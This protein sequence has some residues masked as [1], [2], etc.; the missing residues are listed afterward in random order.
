MDFEKAFDIGTI[1]LEPRLQEYMRRKNF[2]EENDIDPQISEEQEFS[3]TPYDLK[4]IKRFKQGKKKLYSSR[5]L[6][7]DPHF[8]KTSA[9]DFEKT[10]DFKLDPRYQRLQKKMQS[11]RDA[12]AQIKNLDN[13][14]E[15]YTIFHQSN[16]YDLKSNIKSKKMAKPYDDPGNDNMD[17]D[18]EN[19]EFMMDSR[20]LML[21]TSRP[22]KSKNNTRGEY[23]YNPNRKSNNPNN[24]H[25]TPKITY[26]QRLAPTK[27]SLSFQD[28]SPTLPNGGLTHS[29]SVDDVIGN[30]DSYN[31]HLNNSYEYIQ[32]DADLDTKTFTPGTRSR[33]Q[34][35]TQTGYQA[36]PFMYG[37]G[38]PDVTLEDS[39][40]GAIRDTSKK[41]TGFKNSFEHN[42]NYISGDISD[43][44]HSV[45]MWPV[46]SRGQNKEISRPNSNAMQSDRRIRGDNYSV[47]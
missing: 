7:T 20:D 22:S 45:Q 9:N 28:R 19:D 47:Y 23:C 41:S 10:H 3:I 12:Q 35:E 40:R 32:S 43:P 26:N 15:E 27:T 31:K 6:A 13:I 29:R 33:T 4:M 18:S 34:R 17:N 36:I 5:R 16:P 46:N 30:L 42:F 11:H 2:N 24:Y 21:S 44:N 14:D 1:Q 39:L 8:V 38:L 37:N 25:H